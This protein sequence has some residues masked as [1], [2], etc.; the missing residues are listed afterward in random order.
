[1]PTTTDDDHIR[2]VG[3]FRFRVN[4]IRYNIINFNEI[5]RLE[6]SFCREV[7]QMT[8]EVVGTFAGKGHKETLQVKTLY[9]GR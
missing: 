5:L 4:G 9:Y 2:R 6:T 1:M 7:D 8:N 3:A